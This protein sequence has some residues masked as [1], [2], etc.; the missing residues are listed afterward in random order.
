[1]G[2]NVYVSENGQLY[3]VTK[4]SW[5]AF[6]RSRE[7]GRETSL[8]NSGALLLGDIAGEIGDLSPFNAGL[9]LRAFEA[10]D[11]GQEPPAGAST[12]TIKAHRLAFIFEEEDCGFSLPAN[13][14]RAA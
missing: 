14:E 8:M 1:M 6:L 7:A 4:E 5:L 3:A 13:D 11:T 2:V 10:A 12:L 9:L